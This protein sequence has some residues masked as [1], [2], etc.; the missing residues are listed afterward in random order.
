VQRFN[1]LFS[2]LL[3]LCASGSTR[4]GAPWVRQEFS[5]VAAG[6]G[7]RSIILILNPHD[8]TVSATLELFGD[9]GAPQSLTING[10]TA[11]QFNVEIAAGGTK[12]LVVESSSEKALLGWGRLTANR[13]LA[14]Q[15]LFELSS[16][17]KLVTQAAV[18]PFRPVNQATVFVDTTEGNTGV[19]LANVS[20][21]STILIGFTLRDEAGEVVETIHRNLP[22][23]GHLA[24]F[25]SELFKDVG[26]LRGSL[27]IVST[28]KIVLVTLQQTGLVLGT[29]PVITRPE[30]LEVVSAGQ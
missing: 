4:A 30:R 11:S 26:E 19:A 25:V 6:G 15:L 13:T 2:F 21:A 7:I 27:E 17:G 29:L 10:V 3:V 22:P 1:W 8:A 28:G 5:Q 18:E 20:E 16:D 9:D 24:K 23:R 12:R 14:S